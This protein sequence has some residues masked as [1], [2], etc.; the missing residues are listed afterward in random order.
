MAKSKTAPINTQTELVSEQN[1]LSKRRIGNYKILKYEISNQKLK[2]A[3]TTKM[4][5]YHKYTGY[6]L[7][8]KM[9]Y[10][11]IKFLRYR[12]LNKETLKFH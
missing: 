10:N 2:Y 6:K 7:K 4:I 9:N 11:I 12:P 5:V 3:L 8:N 1:V